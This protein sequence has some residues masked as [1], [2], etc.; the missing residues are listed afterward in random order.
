MFY[1]I[2]RLTFVAFVFTLTMPAALADDI[3]PQAEILHWW[4][5]KSES[6]ALAVFVN[7]FQARGGL[8][9]DSS[10]VDEIASREEA[11][12]R[13]GRGYPAT[14]SQWNAGRP[15]IELYEFGLIKPIRSQPLIQRLRS[16]LPAMV[17]DTVTSQGEIIAMPLNLHT[18]N[19]MWYSQDLLGQSEISLSG[20]WNQFFAMGDLLAE[21]KIP[22]F[23]VGNQPW[24]VRIL[25]TSVLLSVSRDRYK[26]FYLSND[27]DV[28]DT[29][30]FRTAL[31]V[32]NKLASYSESFDDD[33]W[34]S[35]IEAVVENRAAANIM[36]DWARG[37]LLSLDQEAGKDYGCLL[38]STD[39]PSLLMVVD[40]LVLGIVDDES[41]IAG[42]ELMLDVV[43][44]TELNRQFNALKGS[45]SPYG[46]PDFSEL[47]ICTSQVYTVMDN[48]EAVIPP[49]QTYFPKTGEYADDVD[50]MT[51]QFWNDSLK[52]DVD[53]DELIEQTAEQFRTIL[54]NITIG[55][56]AANEAAER[57]L[58]QCETGNVGNAA[59]AH[60]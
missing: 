46:Q 5:S 18:E 23:A 40:T 13:M 21:K 39:D 20:D 29:D 37:L 15:I 8:Y 53:S 19:W 49:F 11:I 43:S 32:F 41:E 16:T 34:D 17:L 2:S 59:T 25:F 42:Q 28:T 22:L 1:V 35:Q 36:G 4:S 56:A 55:V 51:Y 14:L 27:A 3:Q 52:A 54:E 26:E 12:E 57:L 24:Q 6:D 38:T 48:E 33:S 60:C 7:E 9:Y 50:R 45:I 47:D 44:D 30:E 10:K 58:Q 31:T